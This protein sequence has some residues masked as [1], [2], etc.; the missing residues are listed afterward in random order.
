M[1]VLGFTPLWG[2]R[3]VRDEHKRTNEANTSELKYKC[4]LQH[5]IAPAMPLLA[6][7]AAGVDSSLTGPKIESLCKMLY[8][9][10]MCVVT[11]V[12]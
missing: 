1:Y 2:K 8:N 4:F 11:L 5:N 7:A 10:S 12:E 3:T 6:H 9:M